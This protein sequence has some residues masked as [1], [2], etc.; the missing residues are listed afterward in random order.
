MGTDAGISKVP[1]S[2]SGMAPGNVLT[3]AAN[4]DPAGGLCGRGGGVQFCVTMFPFN[5]CERGPRVLRFDCVLPLRS[6][7]SLCTRS[8]GSGGV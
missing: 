4:A 6:L 5:K 2:E 3:P 1:Q 8:L 7:S